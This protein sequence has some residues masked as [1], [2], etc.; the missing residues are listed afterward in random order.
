MDLYFAVFLLPL[1]WDRAKESDDLLKENGLLDP[2]HFCPPFVMEIGPI[3]P[4]FL[5]LFSFTLYLSSFLSVFL[6]ALFLFLPFFSSTLSEKISID[7]RYF[8]CNSFFLWLNC[9]AKI[10]NV[11]LTGELQ[12]NV[13]YVYFFN[14]SCNISNIKKSFY[15][16]FFAET[17]N[18]S[19]LSA[20]L[21]FSRS[22]P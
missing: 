9:T 6:S 18:R 10:F 22:T 20:R 17:F 4:I 19:L 7:S 11:F 1:T 16:F 5:F 13:I 8:A 15:I 21:D 3:F 2:R 12:V 14:I